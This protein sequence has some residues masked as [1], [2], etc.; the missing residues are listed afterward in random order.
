MLMNNFK[1]LSLVKKLLVMNKITSENYFYS[2][3]LKFHIL[4]DRLEAFSYN[5]PCR[6]FSQVGLFF[7]GLESLIRITEVPL[8]SLAAMN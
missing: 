2:F 8:N 3:D 7:K 5:R 6:N 1:A 4:L